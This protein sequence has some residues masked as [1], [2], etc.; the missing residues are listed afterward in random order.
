[1]IDFPFIIYTKSEIKD[2]S[3]HGNTILY[4]SCKMLTDISE[5]TDQN[6][7]LSR[8]YTCCSTHV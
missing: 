5:T 2:E 3:C 8:K 7:K 4:D 6:G 1:L